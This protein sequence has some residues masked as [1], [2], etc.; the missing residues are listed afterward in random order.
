MGG[1]GSGAI[2]RGYRGEFLNTTI[3]PAGIQRNTFTPFNAFSIRSL[4]P[5]FFRIERK[6]RPLIAKCLLP[7]ET[8]NQA[9]ASW[10][11]LQVQ[12][13]ASSLSES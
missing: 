1:I 9:M 11:F 2:Q 3:A 13:I 12:G 4:P 10:E 6:K 8:R 5:L 7:E